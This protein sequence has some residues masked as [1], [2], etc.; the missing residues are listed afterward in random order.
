VAVPI[1]FV[2][3]CSADFG[4]GM[5]VTEPAI[6]EATPSD[7][8]KWSF[9]IR[10]LQEGS[11][12]LRVAVVHGDHNDFLSLEVP[13][14][15]TADAVDPPIAPEALFVR[16]G[17]NPLATW[18][19]DGSRGLGVATGPMLVRI[20]ARR[21]DLE[22]VFEGP[23]DPGDGGVES[24]HRDEIP[25]PAGPYALDWTVANES[26]ARLEA[27]AGEITRLDLVG[28]GVGATTVVIELLF[29]GVPILAS[30]PMP[31]VCVDPAAPAVPAPSFTCVASGLKSVIVDQGTVLPPL[32]PGGGAPC[33]WWTPGAFELGEGQETT[34]YSVREFRVSPDP[35]DTVTLG[36]T[37]VRFSFEFADRDIAKI[38]NHPFHWNEITV[39][40]VNGLRAGSTMMTLYAT[41]DDTGALRWVS[42]PMPVTVAAP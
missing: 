24:G 11:T 9:R 7:T 3:E 23:W 13:V 25:V 1:V 28:T 32:P 14:S 15:V 22:V 12:T 38:T 34:L 42:P 30:G 39:F 33:G 20:G 10:G 40:H 6:A 8:E 41:D 35:C 19:H 37:Q 18:N 27:V 4:L 26:V 2:P 29:Q 17:P 5:T 31:V 36:S 16:D 21:A